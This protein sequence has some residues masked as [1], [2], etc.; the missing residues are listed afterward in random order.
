MGMMLPFGAL[1]IEQAR[2]RGQ[3]PAQM[4]L[5]SQV[6]ILP[7]E[8]NPVVIA[9]RAI[10]YRWEWIKGLQACFWTDPRAFISK[11]IIDASRAR[12]AALYRWD[13]V[14]LKGY[15]VMALPDP[16]SIDGGQASWR[17]RVYADR[18]LPSQERTFWKGES[19]WN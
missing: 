9:D 8:A 17:W 12:P 15:D 6:G 16:A 1:P 18:W 10:A 13:C 5:I 19:A 3:R 14:N 2:L 7:F 11:H 4:V